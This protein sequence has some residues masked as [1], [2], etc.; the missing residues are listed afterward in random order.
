M[1]RKTFFQ[2]LSWLLVRLGIF[3]Y[4]NSSVACERYSDVNTNISGSEEEIY[5]HVETT[6]NL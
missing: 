3:Y 1:Q 6:N 5:A 4:L 2:F